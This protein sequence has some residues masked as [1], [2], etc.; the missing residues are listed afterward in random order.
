M[1]MAMQ[2]YRSWPLQLV[3]LM[4]IRILIPSGNAT[5]SCDS[6]GQWG[7]INVLNCTSREFVEL[8]QVWVRFGRGRLNIAL[9]SYD[10]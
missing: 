5:R 2:Y 3:L 7:E 10:K 4:I 9:N 6:D 8:E 1:N